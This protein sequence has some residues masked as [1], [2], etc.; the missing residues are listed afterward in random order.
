MTKRIIRVFPRKTRATPDDRLVAI[1]R[2]PHLLDQ[3]DEVHISVIF[4]WDLVQAEKLAKRWKCVAPVKIG[5][6]ATGQKSEEFIPGKYVKDGYVITSRGCPNKC[7]FCSVWRREGLGIRELPICDGF[8]VLDDN[9]LACSDSHIKAVFSMLRKQDRP[10]KFTGG[11]EAARL[12]DWHI[13]EFL[14]LDLSAAVF[15]YDT[16]D[17][18]E[19]LQEAGKMLVKSG[20]ITKS[21]IVFRAYVLV[22]FPKDNFGAAENRLNETASA[23]F[24][25]YVMLY[26][27]SDNKEPSNS[28]RVF[29]RRW[30]TPIISIK[31]SICEEKRKKLLEMV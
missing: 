4:S 9:L 15:A 20:L 10:V 29:K 14:K 8:D 11:L 27:G 22:G 26:R 2:E 25:P 31:V 5:G 6:P 18:L 23:G 13:E 12:K 30:Q 16:P 21:N 17:D 3:A 1:A 24:F 28:W 19:P 7:W